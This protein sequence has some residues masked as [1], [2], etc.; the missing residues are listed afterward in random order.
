MCWLTKQK[1][2]FYE[3]TKP[4]SQRVISI[5][6]LLE[7][8]KG[9]FPADTQFYMSDSTYLLADYDDIALF[10]AQ[11]QTNK[12][13]YVAEDFDCDNFSYRLMGQFSV[14]EWSKLAFGIVWSNLHALNCVID[15]TGKF[16]Y[17]EPQTDEILE[18]LKDWMGTKIR[19]IIM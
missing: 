18:E 10:L 5:G 16:W 13:D 15:E 9:K 3:S 7:I 12:I 14:P 8:L 1:K 11:D 4:V 17:V 19:F 2:E 6:G